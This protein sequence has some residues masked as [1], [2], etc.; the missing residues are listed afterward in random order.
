MIDT[1]LR[2][3]SDSSQGLFGNI[4]DDFDNTVLTES[5]PALTAVQDDLRE[6]VAQ[7]LALGPT[8]GHPVDVKASELTR[9][10][11]RSVL[12]MFLAVAPSAHLVPFT[13]LSTGTLNILVFSM[14]TYIA[15]IAGQ[16]SVIF[17]MEEPEIA[18]PP[19]TQR[20]LIHFATSKMGQTIVTSHS[21]YVI[22]QFEPQQIVALGRDT[23][24]AHQ[25][26]GAVP[27]VF[28]GQTIPG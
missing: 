13:R 27:G 10:H 3:N 17:A 18:L 6:R 22:E 8:T 16:D 2:T 7:F 11:V 4:V 24:C 12:R 23:R 19:H 21:P 14:L 25:S 20:R 28:Q 5:N 9:E 15:E 1:I 26:M